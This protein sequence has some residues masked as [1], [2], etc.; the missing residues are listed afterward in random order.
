MNLISAFAFLEIL[1][2][3]SHAKNFKIENSQN[4]Y[5]FVKLFRLLLHHDN[6]ITNGY[7]KRK[8][9]SIA[10]LVEQLTCNQ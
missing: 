1:F 5:C 9:A 10:Q 7:H 2:P 4:R 8:E 6:G 3:R